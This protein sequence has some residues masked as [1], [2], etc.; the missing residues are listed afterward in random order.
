MEFP[1]MWG[2]KV[3]DSMF[4]ICQYTGYSSR[5]I[6]GMLDS[7]KSI[8]EIFIGSSVGS[9]VFYYPQ[10]YMGKVIIND[11]HA[12]EVCGVSEK[13]IQYHRLKGKSIE[14]YMKEHI[15]RD[16]SRSKNIILKFATGLGC[17]SYE[18]FQ[19][20]YN[21]CGSYC[22]RLISS[23]IKKDRG[24]DFVLRKLRTIQYPYTYYGIVYNSDKEVANKFNLPETTVKSRR[25]R[26][27]EFKDIIKEKKLYA[28]GYP[29]T[30]ED[31]I[32]VYTD[33]QMAKLC[34]QSIYWVRNRRHYGYSYLEMYM[35]S[36]GEPIK[37]DTKQVKNGVFVDGALWYKS[38]ADC[39]NRMGLSEFYSSIS[40]LDDINEGLG[41]AFVRFAEKYN[42]GYV[43]PELRIDHYTHEH[44]GNKYYCC[45][46][47]EEVEYFNAKEIL[48]LRLRY[49]RYKPESK[50]Y[51]NN[52]VFNQLRHAAVFY[53]VYDS[54]IRRKAEREGV[55]FDEAILGLAFNKCGKKF[56]EVAGVMYN[57][58][59]ACSDKNNIRPTTLRSRLLTGKLDRSEVLSTPV[60]GSLK[61]IEVDKYENGVLSGK[62]VVSYDT[63]K[64]LELKL[65]LRKH[66]ISSRKHYKCMELEE[67]CNTLL[68]EEYMYWVPYT[69]IIFY[70]MAELCDKLGL[71]Y[72]RVMRANKC[73][74]EEGLSFYESLKKYYFVSKK[75]FEMQK[76]AFTIK[77]DDCSVSSLI[78]MVD[79][80]DDRLY[81]YL[82]MPDKT[83]KVLS[84]DE[85][86]AILVKNRL[87]R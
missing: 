85:L 52:G 1:C 3:I 5:A 84:F 27:F 70:S 53:N 18:E 71:K 49:V 24:T 29:F 25:T 22:D 6:E 39:V 2:G 61:T 12:G 68:A 46:L 15:K 28:D 75:C 77:Y 7:G 78:D 79:I 74:K 26:G 23:W 43:T 14:H 8:D 31:G 87:G 41:R 81:H 42:K 48:D 83:M 60:V 80:G 47:N 82:T 66:S 86:F 56:I 57:G 34:G 72:N 9:S 51:R 64:T 73:G 37:S 33:E 36:V 38:T 21:T 40:K 65:G 44:E 32:T 35:G 30:T 76:E 63:L 55:S 67:A 11:K 17:D 50:I 54:S 45:F 4:R 16:S 69:D 13:A 10:V 58:Y 19:S 59:K 20:K 62:Q